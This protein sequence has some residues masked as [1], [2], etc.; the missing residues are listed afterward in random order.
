MKHILTTIFISILAGL[1]YGF[2]VKNSG[3]PK[4]DVII[5][6]CVLAI[7]FILMPLFIYHRYKNKNMEDFK[8]ENYKKDLEDHL[9][10][11]KEQRN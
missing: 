9:N 8:F 10:K 3:N 2:Y 7:A 4:A 5:G 6:I 1:G 11:E